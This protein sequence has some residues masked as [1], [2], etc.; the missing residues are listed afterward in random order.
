MDSSSDSEM[1]YILAAPRRM[2]CRCIYLLV[3]WACLMVAGA[4]SAVIMVFVFIVTPYCHGKGFTHTF[5]S[6]VDVTAFSGGEPSM[7]TCGNGCGTRSN[8]CWII[9]VTFVGSGNR[10]G[11]AV[12][13]QDEVSVT[14]KVCTVICRRGVFFSLF[15]TR[16][17]FLS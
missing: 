17:S 7:C 3:F 14:N 4:V 11:N 12:L 16:L 5:C 1:P 9:S 15:R 10:S 8:A 2:R 6:V 13:K